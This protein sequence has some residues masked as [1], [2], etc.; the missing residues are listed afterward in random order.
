[1]AL[2]VEVVMDGRMNGGEFLQTS[3][4]PKQDHSPFSS[5]KRQ[6]RIL[7]TIVQPAARFL[8]RY[9]SNVLHSSAVRSEFVGHDDFR[10]AIS[11][12]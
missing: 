10:S 3:H 8:F 5:S 7:S 9:V 1:M 4:F 2:L 6:V 11:L 12:H